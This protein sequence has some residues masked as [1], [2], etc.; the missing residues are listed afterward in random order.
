LYHR[1]TPDLNIERRC[2]DLATGLGEVNCGSSS[3]VFSIDNPV[4]MSKLDRY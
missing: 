3:C 4:E 2:D 1:A